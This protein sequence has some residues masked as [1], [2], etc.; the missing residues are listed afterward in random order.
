VDSYGRLRRPTTRK[1]HQSSRKFSSYGTRAA[2]VFVR[3]Y[4]DSVRT[5][6]LGSVVPIDEV[7]PL[8]MAKASQAVFDKTFDACATDAACQRAFPSLREEF[9]EILERLESGD[10]RVTVQSVAETAPLSR[11]R[12][13]EW[14]RAQLYRPSTAANVPWLIHTA[15]SGDWSPIV[16]GILEQARGFDAAY[17]IGLFFS[18]T[19][20]ED[21]AEDMAFLR[22]EDI[23]P[24]SEGTYLRDY[25][26]RQQ[27]TACKHWPKAALPEGFRDRVQSAVPTMFVSGDTDAASPLRLTEQVASAFSNR[28]EIVAR[29]Q[30]HTEWNECVGRLYRQVVESSTARGIDPSSCKPIP[31]PPFRTN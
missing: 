10:A 25:R 8:T 16:E 27:Q 2:Q 28:V 1:L 20:A 7:T 6:Y 12:V 29:G 18:I 9:K 19:C 23:G 3:A 30:G 4:P 11:G 21:C 24:A 14:L 13:V 31:R 15:H 17:G 26:V 22:E 5:V